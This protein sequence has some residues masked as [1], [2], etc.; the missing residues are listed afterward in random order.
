[1]KAKIEKK[2]PKK[3]GFIAAVAK[4]KNKFFD[5]I[6]NA[7]QQH[8]DFNLI[9]CV[10]VGSPGFTKEEFLKYITLVSEQKSFMNIFKNLHKFIL[11]HCSSGFKHSLKEVLQNKG[12]QEQIKYASVV[13]ENG[14]LDKFFEMMQKSEDKVCYG[15]KQ[16]EQAMKWDAIDYLL[17][18]DVLFRS[19]NVK[20]RKHYIDLADA[21]RKSG[22]KVYHFSSMHPS[23][24]RL[25]SLSG[26]AA[27]LRFACEIDED[28][29][30]EQ[31]NKG[32][33]EK[34]GEAN[35]EEEEEETKQ[36][37]EGSEDMEYLMEILGGPGEVEEEEIDDNTTNANKITEII[38]NEEE[39]E[40]GEEEDKGPNWRYKSEKKGE[41]RN[42]QNF[43]NDD[44]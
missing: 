16:V 18:S 40:E 15:P 43:I 7:I 10:V 34:K 30:D 24:E 6:I 35:D 14:I 41:K 11:V 22:G 2:I 13:Q 29:E 27:V 26:I 38:D 42:G 25:N 31:E 1:M 28:D 19:K 9:E 8:V 37:T 4:A 39:E 33:E 20:A 12:V 3:K 21:V 23:G 36:H 5:Y 44:Y 32:K 17:I